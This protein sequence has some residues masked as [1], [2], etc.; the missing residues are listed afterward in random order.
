M[1]ELEKYGHFIVIKGYLEN[2][3]VFAHGGYNG[4]LRIANEIKN[5]EPTERVFVALLVDDFKG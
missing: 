1:R 3:V 2:A 5:K 4:C